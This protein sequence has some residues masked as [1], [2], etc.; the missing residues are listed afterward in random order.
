MNAS[1]RYVARIFVNYKRIHLGVFPSLEDA[2][3]AYDAAVIKYRGPGHFLNELPSDFSEEEPKPTESNRKYL[4]QMDT[5][6]LNTTLDLSQIQTTVPLIADGATPKVRLKNITQGDRDGSVVIKWEF[7]LVDPAPAQDG[8]Q[9]RA[10]FPL[11]TTF[12]ISRDFLVE[13]MTR[14]MDA[15]LGTGDANNRKGRPARPRFNSET[16]SQMLGAEAYARITVSRSKKSDY[17]ANDIGS[18]IHKEDYEQRQAA[19]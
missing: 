16:V 19:A 14:F 9:V 13:K 6:P 11:F 10:G 2:A 18:L 5:Q 7:V 1:G 8:T 4:N 17:V 15:L 3:K 12:D